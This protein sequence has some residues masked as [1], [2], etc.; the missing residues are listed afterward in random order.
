MEDHVN[1]RFSAQDWERQG[2]AAQRNISPVSRASFVSGRGK[3]PHERMEERKQDHLE[4]EVLQDHGLNMLTKESSNR[5][6]RIAT[7]QWI[8]ELCAL[9]VS[10]LSLVA[11]VLI[12]RLREERPLPDWPVSI[13]INALI[14]IFATVMS[15]T[16]SVPIAAGVSQAKWSWFQQYHALSDVEVYDQASRGPWGALKMLWNI[17]WR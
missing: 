16:M 7:Y 2:D 13:T 8:W 3:E 14:S 11:I 4:T 6:S 5:W 1:S 9:L 12:L 10:L 17:R 15:A